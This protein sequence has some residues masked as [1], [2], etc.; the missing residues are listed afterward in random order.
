MVQINENGLLLA[1]LDI[2]SEHRTWIIH[3]I[4]FKDV[5][6]FFTVI[7]NFILMLREK[8]DIF[9]EV[10]IYLAVDRTNREFKPFKE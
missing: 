1:S 9:D 10:Q 4:L 8:G 2:Y 5:S 3:M 6:L 7:R